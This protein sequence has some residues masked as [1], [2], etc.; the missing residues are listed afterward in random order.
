MK[1]SL[2]ASG[3][4][5]TRLIVPLKPLSLPLL[6]VYHFYSVEQN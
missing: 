1:N 2:P 6:T 3:I 5:T 4:L